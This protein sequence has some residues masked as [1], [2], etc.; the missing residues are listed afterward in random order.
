MNLTICLITKGRE[1]YFSSLVKGIEKCLLDPEV[2]LLII[3]NGSNALMKGKIEEWARSL[4][5]T[6]LVR[7]ENNVTSA[8]V[9]W[10]EIYK[11]DLDWAI[12]PSDDDVLEPQII[13]TWR[14]AVNSDTKLIAFA[15]SLSLINEKGFKTGEVISPTCTEKE[16]VTRVAAAFHEPPFLWPGLF[17]RVTKLPKDLPGSRYVFDWW[18]GIQLL[19]SGKV[20]CSDN[21]GAY[22]RIHDEQESNLV[23]SRRKYFEALLCLDE[24]V[25]SREFG[26]WLS[27]ISFLEKLSFWESLIS[28]SPIYGDTSFSNI[29]LTSLYRKV[30]DSCSLV[31]E[32]AEFANRFALHNG[33]L[34]RTGQV[35]TVLPGA[36]GLSETLPGNLNLIIEEGACDEFRGIATL[37]SSNSARYSRRLACSHSGKSSN[38]L[39]IDCASLRAKEV[40]NAADELIMI[41]SQD[42][43]RK[44]LKAH[45]FTS[46]EVFVLQIL[47]RIR[48]IAPEFIR[49]HL[50]TLRLRRR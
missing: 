1:Q 40:D 34:L 9:I 16:G 31:H 24:I 37:V 5:R 2:T 18:I 13:N 17:L 14:A 36:T 15:T 41:L 7:L 49:R 32:K 19:I 43:E 39:T 35:A 48:R 22:Y 33:V 47:R 23:T 45:T 28:F 26:V 46:G 27:N 21:V 3:D 11:R 44:I 12:F 10:Q 25:V 20:E 30:V 4:E 29:L 8:A 38:V 6:E 50:R 42:Y